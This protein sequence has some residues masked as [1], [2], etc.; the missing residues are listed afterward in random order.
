M[1]ALF[2]SF[3]GLALT[4]KEAVEELATWRRTPL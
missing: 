4:R 1:L 2:R 3:A